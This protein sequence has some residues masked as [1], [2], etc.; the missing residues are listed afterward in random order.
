MASK[1]TGED[2]AQIQVNITEAIKPKEEG[3]KSNIKFAYVET[4]LDSKCGIRIPVPELVLQKFTISSVLP[5]DVKL[6]KPKKVA[7]T[8]AGTYVFKDKGIPKGINSKRLVF[9][10]PKFAGKLS[11]LYLP[12]TSQFTKEVG[13]ILGGKKTRTIKKLNLRFPGQMDIAPILY[14]IKEGFGTKPDKIKLGSSFYNSTHWDA[15][16]L[17]NL[18]ELWFKRSGLI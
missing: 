6:W 7:T 3:S 10:M 1:G 16:E 15:A 2:K 18:G 11:H 13:Y 12:K 14:F 8:G 4:Y 9:G 17:T 5:N